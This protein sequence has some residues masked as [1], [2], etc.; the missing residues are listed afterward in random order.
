MPSTNID[1]VGYGDKL[2]ESGFAILPFVVANDAIDEVLA[3]LE[4]LAGSTSSRRGHRYAARNLLGTSPAIATFSKSRPVRALVNPIL[5]GEAFAIRGI[6]F[7]KVSG[8]NWFVGWH[9]DQI[10]PVTERKEVEGFTAWTMKDGV[11]HVRPPA[12]VLE[13]MVT[14]RIHLDDCTAENGALKVIPGTHKLGLLSAAAVSTTVARAAPVLCEAQRGSVL[15]MR[16]LLLHASGRAASP[17][18]RR[19][20]HLEFAAAPLPGGLTWKVWH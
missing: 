8:A 2:N 11:P 6:L 5:G 16:P 17:T 12:S 19:V 14:L 1:L 4:H 10:I 3:D 9:Q 13:N 7:D 15:A 20:I 18:H